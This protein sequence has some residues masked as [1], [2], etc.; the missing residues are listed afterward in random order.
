MLSFI[1]MKD[2]Y[3]VLGIPRSANM[4]DVKAAYRR[5]SKQYH[6]DAHGG[7]EAWLP[8]FREVQEAYDVL[9]DAQR[10]PVYDRLL[11]DGVLH[12]PVVTRVYVQRRS[13]NIRYIAVAVVLLVILVLMLLEL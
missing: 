3:Q 8:E 10:R 5:L 7:E 9:S 4:A 11:A 13:V 6:P 12:S 2:Y 1:A